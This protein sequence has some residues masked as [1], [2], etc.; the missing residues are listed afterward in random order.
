MRKRLSRKRKDNI[1][2]FLIEVLRLQLFSEQ[3]LTAIKNIFIIREETQFGRLRNESM[4]K[5][6]DSIYS[7]MAPLDRSIGG[8]CI[9]ELYFADGIRWHG[10]YPLEYRPIYRALQYAIKDSL[11]TDRPYSP[12]SSLYY[13]GLH[14]E[15]LC[16]KMFNGHIRGI[17]NKPLGTIVSS[18]SD[19]G[20]LTEPLS[21]RLWYAA[22]VVNK[23]KH[24]LEYD[25]VQMKEELESQV[26]NNLEAISMY[27]ICRKLGVEL[28]A[29]QG[30]SL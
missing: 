28:M 2:H 24:D 22:M 3:D 20:L 23:S 14:L 27:F 25:S 13:S 8:L 11:Q 1:N 21:I 29:L 7:V 26:F 15:N 16:K 5:K 17:E 18:L 4:D 9:D 19:K 30:F 12:R 6:M 10:N